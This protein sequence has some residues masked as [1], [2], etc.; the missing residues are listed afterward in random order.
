MAER[1]I[2]L[3]GFFCLSLSFFPFARAFAADDAVGRCRINDG[4][5]HG[6]ARGA[7]V[8]LDISPRPVRAMRELTFTVAL[9]EQGNPLS[10][11]KV[12]VDLSMPGMVMGK[13]AVMLRHLSQGRYEG[14]G[15]IV[16]CPSGSKVWKATV[17]IQQGSATTRIPFLLEVE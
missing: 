14:K 16:R 10:G 4:P 8:S 9:R 1:L 12:G 5:C 2:L 15:V 7:V 11:A 6:T 3:T 13:N 17:E